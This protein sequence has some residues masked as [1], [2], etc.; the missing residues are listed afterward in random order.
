MGFFVFLASFG[1]YLSLSAPGVTVGDSGEFMTAAATWSL[2]H[3]P[4]YPLYVLLARAFGELLRL[5]DWGYRMNLFSG[6]CASLGLS[7]F[8]RWGRLLGFSPGASLWGTALLA[9]NLDF[10]DTALQTEVFSLNLLCAIGIGWGWRRRRSLSWIGL[11]FGLGLGNHHTLVLIGPALLWAVLREGAGWGALRRWGVAVFFFLLGFSIYAI[12]P[13]RAAQQ[14][15]LNWGNPTSTERFW[16]VLSRKDYGTFSLTVEETQARGWSS[17]AVQSKRFLEAFRKSSSPW[18][19]FFGGIG[20]LLWFYRRREREGLGV[21]LLWLFFSGPFFLW[22]GNPPASAQVEGALGRFYALPAVAMGFAWMAFFEFIADASPRLSRGW[23]VLAAAFPL[24][25]AFWRLPS[26]SLRS[27]WLALDYGRNLLRSLPQ[28]ALFLM[29][30]GDDTFYTS[31]YLRYVRGELP[32]VTLADRGGLVFPGLYG[33]DFRQLSREEKERRRVRVER[34]LVGFRP[35]YYSTMRSDLVPGLRLGWIGLVQKV[36]SEKEAEN[37]WPLSVLRNRES[38]RFPRYRE[39][40]LA[41]FF[42]YARAQWEIGR[43]NL[44]PALL[45][46]RW[47]HRAGGDVEW[48]EPNLRWEWIRQGYR[49]AESRQWLRAEAFYREGMWEFPEDPEFPL[50]LGVS[51]EKREKFPEAEKAYRRALELDPRSVQAHYNLGVLYW[52]QKRWD[53][54]VQAFEEVLRLDPSHGQ[55]AGYLARARELEGRKNR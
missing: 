18:G 23:K 54:V 7:L 41:A 39:R 35:V 28:R 38:L 11:L 14:P 52:R 40:A 13:F 37:L 17:W 30:G 10:L 5:G 27:Q 9:C 26:R 51:L 1:A 49:F 19:L 25:F 32:E 12:L 29:E 46:G 43:N 50:N 21:A 2:P 44:Q 22:L 15:P 24:L 6:F 55:A 31:A 42:P 47:A 34:S 48:L 3:A 8:Y 36:L 53:G 45:W 33:P 16:R 20:F 4:G